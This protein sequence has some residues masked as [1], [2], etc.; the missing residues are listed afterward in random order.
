MI[1]HSA[2]RSTGNMRALSMLVLLCWP[3]LAADADPPLTAREQKLMERIDT[4]EQRLAALEAR[5]GSAPATAPA[6]SPP[7]T[8]PSSKNPEPGGFL[9]DTTFNMTLD[10]YY[11][12]NF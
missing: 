5:V 7:Q 4:L 3:V 2:T 1:S 6:D 9:S 10:G 8:Q 11:G 12:Y